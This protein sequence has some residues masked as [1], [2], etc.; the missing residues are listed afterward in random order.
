MRSRKEMIVKTAYFVLL[1]DV[2]ELC[3][4][5]GQSVFSLE[6]SIGGDTNTNTNTNTN[7]KKERG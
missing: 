2:D 6:R 7:T 1:K 3:E 5:F 4:V